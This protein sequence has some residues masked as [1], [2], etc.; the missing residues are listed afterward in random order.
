MRSL[1]VTLFVIFAATG[2]GK[3]DDATSSQTTSAD[4]A[5]SSVGTVVQTSNSYIYESGFQGS[6]SSHYVFAKYQFKE[7]GCDTGLHNFSSPQYGATRAQ[8]CSGLYNESMNHSCARDL[9]LQ[10]A[11]QLGC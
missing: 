1:F 11:S 5:T 7:N 9:R 10:Y 6:E 8:L 4:S 3:S 2:C